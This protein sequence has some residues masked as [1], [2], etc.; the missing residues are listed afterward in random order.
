MGGLGSRFSNAGYTTPKPLIPVDGMPMFKKAL[1]SIEDIHTDIDYHFV[2]R[3][4][5]ADK[6]H[7]DTL[8]TTTLPSANVVIIPEM[9]RGA[10]ETAYAAAPHL[11]PESPLIIMDC[12]LWF[13]SQSYT[14]I[15]K[16]VLSGQSSIKGGLLTFRADNPRYSYAQIEADDL[17]TKT[18][19]KKVISNHAITGA[20]LF[21][22]AKVFTHATQLLLEQ[23]LSEQMP[24]YYISNLYNIILS[25]G[26]AIKAGYVDEFASFGTPEELS[27]Y[28]D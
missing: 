17:V 16:E 18:A 27:A 25:E 28:T 3:K 9:T 5:H 2:I 23:P 26:G 24:E 11:D 20:Y 15:I 7:L 19:E 4:E 21:E 1:S 13:K 10:A 8:I 6:L 22:S 12:D 14:N